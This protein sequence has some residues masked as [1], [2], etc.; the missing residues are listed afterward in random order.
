M[1][2]YG[3]FIDKSTDWWNL[4]SGYFCRDNPQLNKILPRPRSTRPTYT[5]SSES[6]NFSAK[7]IT[8]RDRTNAS[9]FKTTDESLLDAT[10]NPARSSASSK[11][12]LSKGEKNLKMKRTNE[13][14]SCQTRTISKRVVEAVPGKDSTT[15][16]KKKPLIRT[17]QG[18]FPEL[19]H[20]FI[21]ECSVSHP[22]VVKWNSNR[23]AFNVEIHHPTLPK[24]LSKYFQ[25]KFFGSLSFFFSLQL[26]MEAFMD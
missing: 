5:D 22:D 11:A 2:L 3:F 8:S 25:R 19:L 9:A 17:L 14:E 10:R 20:K 16:T 1:N 21:C 7:N 12:V 26:L 13:K 4:K 23:T 24:L 18:P 6:F 15:S